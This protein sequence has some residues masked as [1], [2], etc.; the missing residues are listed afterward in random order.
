MNK[1]T[2]NVTVVVE[3]K[4]KQDHAAMGSAIAEHLF[5]TFNDDESIAQISYRKPEDVE[6]LK[7]LIRDLWAFIENGDNER[8]F[9]LRERVR[10][11]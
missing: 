3:F 4:R 5:E 1:K 7:A 11:L 2:H 9:A 6:Q 8:F 10:G